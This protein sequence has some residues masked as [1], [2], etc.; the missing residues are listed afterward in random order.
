MHTFFKTPR[1]INVLLYTAYQYIDIYLIAIC[2][3]TKKDNEPEFTIYI[4]ILK[5]YTRKI[6]VTRDARVYSLY[7]ENIISHQGYVSLLIVQNGR[8]KYR[9]R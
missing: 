3:F 9:Q 7:T 2:L 5:L 1:S 4:N 6:S 8:R